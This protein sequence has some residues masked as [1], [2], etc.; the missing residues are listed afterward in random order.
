MGTDMEIALVLLAAVL[1]V[2]VTL[3]VLSAIDRPERK[4]RR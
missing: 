2:A 4:A 3:S 1:W